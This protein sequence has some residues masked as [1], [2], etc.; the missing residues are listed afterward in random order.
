MIPPYVAMGFACN[1]LRPLAND[2][3]LGCSLKRREADAD[4]DDAEID[5]SP[6]VGSS[7]YGNEIGIL[8]RLSGKGLVRNRLLRRKRTD[9]QPDLRSGSCC[10]LGSNTTHPCRGTGFP[11]GTAAQL[12]AQGCHNIGRPRYR[13][14]PISVLMPKTRVRT[15]EDTERVDRE[16][17]EVAVFCCRSV[18]I[19][20][21]ARPDAWPPCRPEP[22]HTPRA[23]SVRA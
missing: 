11:R 14:A 2:D 22:F 16:R 18:C 8:R 3:E 6:S 12:A 10:A 19:P 15:L 7:S 21:S 1:L 20:A 9:V 23:P 5:R 17:I 13:S 4:I